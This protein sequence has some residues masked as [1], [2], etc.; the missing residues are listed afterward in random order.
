VEFPTGQRDVIYP[1][2]TK[3]REY[4]DGSVRKI[5]TNGKYETI[6]S[7]D[8][9]SAQKLPTAQNSSRKKQRS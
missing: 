7:K 6:K 1:D 3:V 9:T 5:Y 2:G 4:E 8:H